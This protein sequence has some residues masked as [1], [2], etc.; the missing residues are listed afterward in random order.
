LGSVRSVSRVHAKSPRTA[1]ACAA[2]R[3]R[4]S[5]ICPHAVR[6]NKAIALDPR[7]PDVPSYVRLK[8]AGYLLIGSYNE[9]IA[10]CERSLALEDDWLAHMDLVAAYAQKGDMA[11]TV[12]AKADLLQGQPQMSIA[13][14][15]ALRLSDNSIFLQQ[16]EDHVYPGLR[17][18]GI[19]EN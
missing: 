16:L 14:V 18:A 17:K 5:K 12:L 4:A 9:A 10:A 3:I 13:H 8:C 1:V 11:K 19:P 15:K 6:S 2:P 7:N